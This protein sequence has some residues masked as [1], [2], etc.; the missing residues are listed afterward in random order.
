MQD[1]PECDQPT[2]GRGAF[3]DIMEMLRH[4]KDRCTCPLLRSRAYYFEPNPQT[5]DQWAGER[6]YLN[7]V[8]RRVAFV[9]ESPGAVVLSEDSSEVIRCWTVTPQDARFRKARERYG[10]QDCYLT[11]TVKC[12]VRRG[13]RHTNDELAAC[14]PHL[15]RE[16]ELLKPQV[17]VGVGGN[18]YR[19]FRREVLPR[20]TFQPVVFQLTHYSARGDVQPK[21]E[22]EFQELQRL[23][24]RLKP[25]REWT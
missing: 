5:R 19:H 9:C 15:I 24:R 14:R 3:A 22:Q 12:G 17:A 1:L 18:A 8:D 2:Q 20:L 16:I 4:C 25:T 13:A 23:V 10:F 6:L 21:W 11:N 7:G